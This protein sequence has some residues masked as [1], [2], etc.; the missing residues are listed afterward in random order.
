M[1]NDESEAKPRSDI[2]DLLESAQ[3]LHTT[4]ER[5][6]PSGFDLKQRISE[7]ASIIE[8][9]LDIQRGVDGGDILR[10]AKGFL[11]KVDNPTLPRQLRDR[12]SDAIMRAENGIED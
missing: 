5:G 6:T 8:T 10:A 11:E 12:L 9:V 1:S 3:G 2:I 4:D 7:V